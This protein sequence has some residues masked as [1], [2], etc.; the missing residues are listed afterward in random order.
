M[1]RFVCYRK[2]TRIQLYEYII[3]Y[4]LV[5][6]TTLLKDRKNKDQNDYNRRKKP[7]EP[8]VYTAQIFK[9]L[10]SETSLIMTLKRHFLTIN[11]YLL[12]NKISSCV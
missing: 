10:N 7:I 1:S 3:Y 2:A 9:N 12:Y 8:N 5:K 11:Q 4:A 6:Q